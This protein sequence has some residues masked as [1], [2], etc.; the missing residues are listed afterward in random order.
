MAIYGSRTAACRVALLCLAA[1]TAL[2]LGVAPRA[3][4]DGC[5][6]Q[7]PRPGAPAVTCP[8]Q[9]SFTYDPASSPSEPIAPGTSLDFNASGSKGTDGGPVALYE[10]DWGTGSYGPA[11]GSPLAAH[12]F[13]TR[14]VYT[15]GLRITDSSSPAETATTTRTV[16]VGAPPAPSFTVDRQSTSLHETVTFSGTASEPGYSGPF[17]YRWDF[18][19]DG[20]YDDSTSGATAAHVYSV[21]GSY[22]PTVEV[23]DD[24]GVTGTYALPSPI[25]ASN[26]PPTA[27]LALSASS[28]P[29][30]G[31]ITLDGSASSDADSGGGLTYAWDLDGDGGFE[32]AAAP[33]VMAHAFPNPGVYDIHVR[34]TDV[35][36]GSAIATATLTVTGAGG[37]AGG[38]AGNGTID[39]GGALGPSDIAGGASANGTGSAIGAGSTSSNAFTAGLAGSSIQRLKTVGKRGLVVT[40]TASRAAT[41]SAT[42]WISAKDARRLR[43]R[44]RGKQPVKLGAS[45]VNVLPTRGAPLTLKISGQA[46]RALRRT[47]TLRVTVQ[48]MA[49][50]AAGTSAKLSRAVIVR[51]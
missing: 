30:G 50:D 5:G 25:V 2:A 45:S 19:G 26:Q 20:T 49:R 33:A 6:T 40:C 17:T 23:T 39:G 43:L 8:P 42:A 18:D 14:G 10:W 41:C 28:I 46:L 29:A 38:G 32:M 37:D 1:A 4:A 9:A 36:G 47:R 12:T 3:E 15:V 27:R 22:T 7:L 44:V 13:S 35:D 31:T 24:I 11:S 16:Y 34:V 51:R 21:A 48:G